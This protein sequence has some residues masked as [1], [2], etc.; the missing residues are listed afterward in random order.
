[1][2]ADLLVKLCELMTN[3]KSKLR[4]GHLSGECRVAGSTPELGTYE[5]LVTYDG[6]EMNTTGHCSLQHLSI[7]Q[8]EKHITIKVVRRKG[9]YIKPDVVLDRNDTKG[10]Q[11]WY[12]A[13]FDEVIAENRRPT[14]I[15][16]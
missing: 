6:E 11:E 4:N 10:L 9:A 15:N 7:K 12:N 5:I 14:P 16:Y 13:W 8:D 2:R 3:P 1:M